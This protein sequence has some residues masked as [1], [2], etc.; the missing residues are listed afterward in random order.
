[1]A[2]ASDDSLLTLAIS[3]HSNPGVY[4]L[5]LGSGVSRSAGIPT[6]WEIVLDL[7]RRL[8][9]ADGSQA[10]SD[11]EKWYEQVYGEP[12]EYT[13]ILARLARTPSERRGLLRP[14]FEPTEEERQEGLK[15]PS[16]A[17]R[18]VARLVGF[19]YV[20]MILTTNFDRLIERALADEGIVPDVVSSNDDFRGAVP[21]VHSR[22]M[23]VK[24]HGD[25]MDTRIRNTS[26]ELARYPRVLNEFLDRVLDEFGLLVCGWSAEWDTGLAGAI[27]RSPS[28][29]FGMYWLARGELGQE[30]RRIVDHRRADIVSIE[31]ADA[32]FLQL[33]EKVQSLREIGRTRPDSKGVAVATVKRYLM[34]PRFRI[35]LDDLLRDETEL[36]YS[37][38]MSQRFAVTAS[39]MSKEEF[40]QRVND[41]E[42]TA[43]RL[44][45]VMAALSY[46]DEGSN[47]RLITRCI[48]RL[49]QVTREDGLIALL[50]LRFYP[51]LLVLYA[52]G[53][54]ALAGARYNSLA[55]LLRHPGCRDERRGGTKPAIHVLTVWDVFSGNTQKWAP[56]R[57]ENEYTPV[58]NHLLDLLRPVLSE[59]QPDETNQEA[60]F[61]TF[62]YMLALTHLDLKG[63]GAEGDTWSP[64]GRF[65]WRYRDDWERAPCVQF[66]S[67]GLEHA[68][69][70]DL[71]KAG[72]FGGSP[73]RAR[74]VVNLHDRWLRQAT[75]G[76][77]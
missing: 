7:I 11:P 60:T 24:L 22:C 19:G 39:P 37:G 50:A 58:S 63:A 53:V 54:P 18:A 2:G 1:M 27:R 67:A 45:A 26:R 41:Y 51:A 65:A 74:H 44:A 66:V 40:L 59:Y 64:P 73:A 10:S 5:L 71:L 16:E 34:E 20:R 35:R 14:Y 12:A 68:E 55:A 13:S 75:S 3:L 43:D 72:F 31:S 52:A 57:A 69:D 32:A 23:V 46:Y 38:F 42:D 33:A 76:W 30:A 61:D 25:Y 62:E 29:R 8:A 36:A 28:R 21:Y 47:S 77:F 70:W 9:V 48:E 4:A 15:T 56:G 6:G 49:V 17:H